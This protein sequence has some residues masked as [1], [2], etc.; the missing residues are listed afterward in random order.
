MCI[1]DRMTENVAVNGVGGTPAS[2]PNLIIYNGVKIYFSDSQMFSHIFAALKA[3]I[4]DVAKELQNAKA[5]L[6]SAN[7]ALASARQALDEAEAA[8]QAVSQQ[9]EAAW[10]KYNDA[11]EAWRVAFNAYQDCLKKREQ[12]LKEHPD[13]CEGQSVEP[14]RGRVDGDGSPRGKSGKS[15]SRIATDITILNSFLTELKSMLDESSSDVSNAESAKS[16]AEAALR[17]TEDSYKRACESS[18]QATMEIERQVRQFAELVNSLPKGA[19]ILGDEVQPPE[20][21]K[22]KSAGNG[23]I[24][25]PETIEPEIDS[26]LRANAASLAAMDFTSS[27]IEPIIGDSIA[28]LAKALQDYSIASAELKGA[29]AG[30]DFLSSEYAHWSEV[31]QSRIDKINEFM[32]ETEDILESVLALQATDWTE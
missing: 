23:W 16:A 27:S 7:A 12:C 2:G 14:D 4:D 3:M 10:Q 31:V 21:F 20:G 18:R 25:Y 32:D 26:W 19:F 8:Y 1:R 29:K 24:I 30:N 15:F 22:R 13:E 11:K 5:E 28:N 17:Q 9:E 6:A